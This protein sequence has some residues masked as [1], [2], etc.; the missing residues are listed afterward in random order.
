LK[1]IGYDW[2]SLIPVCDNQVKNGK[3]EK[4]IFDLVSLGI[5]TNRDEWVYDYSIENLEKK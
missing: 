1:S 2:R 3:T 5:A 4:A